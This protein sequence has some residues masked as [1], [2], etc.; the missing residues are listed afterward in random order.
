MVTE[1]WKGG[2]REARAASQG[3][4]WQV[5]VLLFVRIKKDGKIVRMLE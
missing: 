1:V 3:F 4:E 5:Q 2:R